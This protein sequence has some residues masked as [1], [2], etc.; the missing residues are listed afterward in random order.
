MFLQLQPQLSQP[1]FSNWCRD[2]YHR[3]RR[4]QVC[5]CMWWPV[6]AGCRGLVKGHVLMEGKGSYSMFHRLLEQYGQT[7]P[8]T[9]VTNTV[10]QFGFG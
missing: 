1:V 8:K 10:I 3:Q 6:R 7:G 9:T 5:P 4:L 2:R